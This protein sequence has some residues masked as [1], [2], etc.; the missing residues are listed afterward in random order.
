L[1]LVLGLTRWRFGLVLAPAAPQGTGGWIRC[2]GIL[3]LWCKE[4]QR[5]VTAMTPLMAVFQLDAVTALSARAYPLEVWRPLGGDGKLG[6]N[7]RRWTR[8]C[9]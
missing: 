3:W 6:S 2:H 4:L 8:G 1:A 7:S 5:D 9:L